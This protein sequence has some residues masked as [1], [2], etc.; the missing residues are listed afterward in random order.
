[1]LGGV[2]QLAGGDDLREGERGGSERE[3]RKKGK[4]RG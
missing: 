4:R 1:M 2:E 3:D